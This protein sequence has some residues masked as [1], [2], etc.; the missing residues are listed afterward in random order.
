MKLHEVIADVVDRESGISTANAEKV[1]LAAF[2][3]KNLNAHESDFTFIRSEEDGCCEICYS[4]DIEYEFGD[5]ILR[6]ELRYE[7]EDST[8]MTARAFIW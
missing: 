6:I 1:I 5:D 8:V 4:H 7:D 2:E 3:E